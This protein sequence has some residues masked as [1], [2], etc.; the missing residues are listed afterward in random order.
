MARIYREAPLNSVW[1]G[2][3]NMMCMDVRRA[4]SRSPDCRDALMAEFDDVRGQ[5]ARFD[6]FVASLGPLVD[7]MMADEY[8]ARPATEALARAI[9]GA[10]LIRHST[11]EVVDAFTA[12]RLGGPA[13]NW[14][15]MFGTMGVAVSKAQ[16]DA[17]V[18]R[19][20]VLR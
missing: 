5:D 18:E 1:E 6:R 8:L 13:G 14:G 10:E 3:A 19:A 7:G 11:A 4:L 15:T 9:Q 12:T 2:T 16:A 20:Q 17:I